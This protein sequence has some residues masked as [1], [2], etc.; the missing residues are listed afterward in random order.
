MI[1]LLK[2]LQKN[3]IRTVVFLTPLFFLP[4]TQEFFQTNKFYLLAGLLLILFI[5]SALRLFFERKITIDRSPFD[6]T[7]VLVGVA[8]GLSV[9]MASI[10]KFQALTALPMGLAPLVVLLGLFY[11]FNNYEES[12]KDNRELFNILK[13]ST[14]IAAVISIIFFFQPLK[15]AQLDPSLGF[16]KSPVFSVIGNQIDSLVFFGFF[17]LGSLGF[18][19]ISKK[20]ERLNHALFGGVMLIAVVLG[21]FAIIKPNQNPADKIQ[22]PP[23]SISWLTSVETLK[24]PL[25]AAFGFGVDN[26]SSVFSR[27]KTPVYNNTDYWQVNFS[28]SRS[29]LLHLWTE[30]GLVG[31]AVFLLLWVYII[32]ELHGLYK[33]KDRQFY[34]LL[35]LAAYVGLIFL[36]LPASFL[37]W[38]LLI[39]LLVMISSASRAHEESS[40]V[41]VDLKHIPLVYIL[42]SAFFLIIS[43]SSGYLLSKTY[44]A[45]FYFK[46]SIDAIR[47]NR[48]QDVYSNMLQAIR[49]NPYI[50]K[51]HFQFSQLNLL[52]ANNLAKKKDLTDQDRQTITQFIQQAIAEGKRLVQLNPTKST[53]WANLALIYRNIINIAQ[54]AESWATAAYER[55]TLLDPSNPILRVNLGGVYYSLKNYDLAQ[56]SF[57]QAVVLKRDWAN[58]H[59]NLAWSLYQ[60]GKYQQAVLTLQNVLALLPDRNSDDYKNVQKNLEEFKKKL[61]KA[62]EPSATQGGELKLQTP[63]APVLSPPLDLPKESG[64]DQEL[65][66]TQQQAPQP[67]VSPTPTV[68]VTGTVSVSPT[69]GQ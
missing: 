34:S 46:K 24:N 23:A 16:L 61:P 1:T 41:V 59:Y 31:L 47:T 18:I 6:K 30:A 27:V 3:L 15:N 43:V 53:S 37:N 51:Y 67:S 2:N 69:G 17:L 45:E 9:L 14:I 57:E 44:R 50:E 5:L 62:V 42:L 56:R 36:L 49:L 33:D 63:P 58:A 60:N 39:I 64:P 11:Y 22:F 8:S 65:K 54:G 55:A 66:K 7:L 68:S 32:R 38:F 40:K 10:N 28:Q 13:I 52:L 35:V 25:T 4:F 26:F 21:I 20:N 48:G 29:A 12:T 19:F